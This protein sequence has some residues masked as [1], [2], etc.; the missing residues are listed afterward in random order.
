MLDRLF[1]S[2]VPSL[3]F[4]YCVW[5][6]KRE[7]IT[8]SAIF[9]VKFP[10][11]KWLLNYYYEFK[12]HTKF[13]LSYLGC[14]YVW[15][16]MLRKT[17]LQFNWCKN[18]KTTDTTSMSLYLSLCFVSLFKVFFRLATVKVICYICD[19]NE[20]HNKNNSV[21]L[22]ICWMTSRQIDFHCVP[23]FFL[24]SICLDSDKSI[25]KHVISRT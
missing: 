7:K 16:L 1:G 25:T 21:A 17:M 23:R 22:N 5:N 11:T 9:A 3:Q 6:A 4:G 20:K 24:S 10:A 13:F 18:P 8:S 19:D 15:A 2:S 14:Y 12:F